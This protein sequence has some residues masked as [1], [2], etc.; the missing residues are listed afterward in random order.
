VEQKRGKEKKE[1][2]AVR[3]SA[4]D[5]IIFHHSYSAREGEGNLKGRGGRKVPSI[6]PTFPRWHRGRK[7]GNF[8]VIGEECGSH[9]FPLLL[10]PL[11]GKREG[12][13]GRAAFR[14]FHLPHFNFSL[15]VK[16]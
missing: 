12:V 13:I 7:G 8:Q 2:E 1:E 5:F 16:E 11:S 9:L 15:R 4:E 14:S 3:R 6:C 10:I